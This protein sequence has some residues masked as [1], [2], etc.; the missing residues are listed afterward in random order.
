MPSLL[1][2]I[3]ISAAVKRALKAFLSRQCSTAA[4]GLLCR[5]SGM[6]SLYLRFILPCSKLAN[7]YFWRSAGKNVSI[8]IVTIPERFA[9]SRTFGR[10]VYFG[11]LFRA[12][13]PLFVSIWSWKALSRKALVQRCKITMQIFYSLVPRLSARTQTIRAESRGRG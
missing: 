1:S 8:K 7:R 2:V 11:A 10:Y 12:T 5:Y 4:F 3:T 9:D 6:Q 13:V